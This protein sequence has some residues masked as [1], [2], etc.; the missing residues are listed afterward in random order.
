[1]TLLPTVESLLPKSNPV[2]VHQWEHHPY[3]CA[4]FCTICDYTL[5]Y[6]ELLTVHEGDVT[7]TFSGDKS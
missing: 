4:F 2:C 1:M 6:L 7:V 5:T 3:K